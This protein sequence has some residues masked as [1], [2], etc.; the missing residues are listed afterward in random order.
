MPGTGQASR[1][2]VLVAFR[3]VASRTSTACLVRALTLQR[4]LAHNGHPSELRIGVARSGETLQAHAWLM[5]NT[6]Q[7]LVGG[8]LEAVSF[9][10][11]AQWNEGSQ[12]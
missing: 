4:L 9:T 6:G 7:T 12:A 2:D 3:R 1:D 8:G 5:D 11:I 10:V